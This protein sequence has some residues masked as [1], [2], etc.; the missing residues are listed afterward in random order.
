MRMQELR[1]LSNASRGSIRGAIVNLG[2]ATSL[3]AS[4]GVLPYTA[5]KHAALGLTKN[6]GKSHSNFNQNTQRCIMHKLTSLIIS[7]LDNASYGIRVNCVCPSWT[8]TP[9]VRRAIEGVEG[10]AEF[11]NKAVPLGR[12]AVPEEVADVVVFLCS[13]R[14]SYMTGCALIV[15]GGTTLTALR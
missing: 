1:P 12:I 7:A 14:S 3:V 13:P 2:S 8:D 10:L 15:D 9:M 4:P 5:S 6:S 11:I